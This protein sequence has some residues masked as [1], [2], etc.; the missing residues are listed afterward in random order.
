MKKAQREILEEV[1]SSLR[2]NEKEVQKFVEKRW[3]V[4]ANW[5]ASLVRV[6]RGKLETLLKLDELE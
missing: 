5:V 6:L 1:V 3:G 4:D 2:A